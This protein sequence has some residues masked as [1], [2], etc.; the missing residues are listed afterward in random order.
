MSFFQPP[1]PELVA[2]FMKFPKGSNLYGVEL[3]IALKIKQN[4]VPTLRLLMP[5]ALNLCKQVRQKVGPDLDQ[6]V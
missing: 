2:L 3:V 5:S 6:T 4:T 1:Y